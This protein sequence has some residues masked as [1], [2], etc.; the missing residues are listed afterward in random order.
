MATE[1][2][3]N[4]APGDVAIKLTPVGQGRLEIYL[5]GEKIFDRKEDSGG[6]PNLTKVNELKMVI[7]EKL[8]E[9]DSALA[10]D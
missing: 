5:D 8:F 6:F 7:A 1:F 10:S 9:F 3:R 4:D 2:Y